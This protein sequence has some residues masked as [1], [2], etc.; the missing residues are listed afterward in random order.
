MA[1]L[2]VDLP[3]DLEA[4]AEEQAGKQGY[5]SADAYIR[6]LIDKARDV[7]NLRALLLEGG[8]SPISGVVDEAY[9]EGLYERA[10][11]RSSS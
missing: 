2:R 4:F 10:R 8:A 9:I 1:T 11:R 6:D 5:N 3:D 7:E